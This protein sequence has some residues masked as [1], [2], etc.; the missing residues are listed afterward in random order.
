ML[1]ADI[2]FIKMKIC[3]DS[4]GIFDWHKMCYAQEEK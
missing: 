2:F 1:L 3:P 4:K